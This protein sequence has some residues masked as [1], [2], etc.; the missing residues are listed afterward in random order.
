VTSGVQ[1]GFQASLEF[2]SRDETGERIV[3]SF[4]QL[5]ARLIETRRGARDLVLQ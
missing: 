1:R 5:F 4:P 2:A 3:T